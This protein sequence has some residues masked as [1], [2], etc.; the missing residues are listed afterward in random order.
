[1]DGIPVSRSIKGGETMSLQ[2]RAGGAEDTS[3]L[4]SELL[5]VFD[6]A[7]DGTWITGWA[8]DADRPDR[9]VQVEVLIDDQSIGHYPAKNHRDDIAKLGWNY[10][11]FRIKVPEDR[12]DGN[13]HRVDVRFVETGTP[14]RDSPKKIVLKSGGEMLAG[15]LDVVDDGLRASGWARSQGEP[16]R[17][18]EVDAFVDGEP[19]G[20]FV[21]KERRDDIAAKGWKD[22]AFSIQI[23]E[24]YGDG[25][26]H[27]IEVRFADTGL[28]LRNGE[29]VFRKDLRKS[30]KAAPASEVVEPLVKTTGRFET[31]EVDGWLAGWAHRPEG[32]PVT[33]EVLIDDEVA[34]SVAADQFR[35]DLRERG[36]G[37]CAFWYRIPRFFN[38]GRKHEI[39]LR[40]A[41]TKQPLDG[42]PQS[43]SFDPVEANASNGKNLFPNAGL[44]LWPNGL[45]VSPS[46]RFEEIVSGWFF[47]MRRGTSPQVTFSADKPDDIALAVNEYAMKIEVT[48]GG[49][50]GYM[51]LVIPLSVKPEEIHR[52]RFSLGARRAS[53]P[54]DS[55]L[56]V[57]ETFLGVQVKNSVQ[58]VSTIRR[59]LK[60]KGTVRLS[61]LQ[62]QMGDKATEIG[63]DA[64]L[65]IVI[66][67]RGE[68]VLTLFSPALTP[69]ATRG[70]GKDTTQ[71]GEFEDPVIRSQI[72]HLKLSPL[73][74][75]NRVVAGP[76]GSAPLPAIAPRPHVTTPFIQIVVPVF[77]AALDVEALLDSVVR[78]TNTPY[79][80]LLFDDG[81]APYTESRVS[82]WEQLDP[83]VRY[84]RNEENVGYTRNIN[85]GL[86]SSISDY[87]VLI[88]SDTIVTPRWLEKMFQ[89]M[90]LDDR[91]AAVG[92]LSNAASWQSVPKTKAPDGDWIIN[93]FD[94]K[95]TPDKISEILE[96]IH[97]GSAPEFP[98]LNG[99]C[100]LFRRSALEE[101]GYFDDASFP[102]GYGE[103]NDL[104][105]RLGRAG[106]SLRVATDTFV[107]H[108]KSK[109]FGNAKRKQFSKAANQILREK[110]PEVSFTS[111]EDHM[112]SDP[113]MARIRRELSIR[114]A[115]ERS[116]M[117]AKSA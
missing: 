109:S 88:N 101:V 75:S 104:C 76:G 52:Y 18:V 59:A 105:L 107:H 23:P 25:V 84:F 68:G 60:Q 74:R 117:L 56:H 80:V 28:P 13:E 6:T 30:A 70:L 50:D 26:E 89:T 7:E 36:L 35:S 20:R 24:I 22:C 90:S 1:M 77:N 98:L 94:E 111:I 108:S 54:A 48:S 116:F 9:E 51:R 29:R 85:R 73:W 103:E 40:A 34:G 47:D 96:E 93:K 58:K 67:L 83:R 4:A 62:L 10:C 42:S 86:Q 64:R 2:K 99:F 44:T 43:F 55:D 15:V 95:F 81:S 31:I 3:L 87:V 106:W 71:T 8:R 115:V 37:D 102:R 17:T 61:Q 12:C 32:G 11:A 5:G 21:A 110:H 112:R 113:A 78:S 100:T 46:E 39:V 49:H 27:T 91:I 14:L 97:D 57:L 19:I 33:V 82:A 16:D 38:D 69:V 63:P 79:E 53:S 45:I 92:P 41:D 65:C 66:D 114:V 72:R